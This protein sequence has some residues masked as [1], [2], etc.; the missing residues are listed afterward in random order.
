ML[1]DAEILP[2]NTFSLLDQTGRGALYDWITLG[3]LSSDESALSVSRSVEYALNN[4]SLYQ[5][6]Q[7]EVPGDAQKIPQPLGSMAEQL[8]S[9][10]HQREHDAGLYRLPRASSGQWCIQPLELQPSVIR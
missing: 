3:Y 7:G 1:K 10:R 8:V 6:T 5:V 9:Q 4:F 2:Y